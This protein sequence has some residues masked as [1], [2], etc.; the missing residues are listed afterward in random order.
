LALLA[1]CGSQTANEIPPTAAVRGKVLRHD[2]TPFPGGSIEFRSKGR[3]DL[4]LVGEIESDGTF[5]SLRTL[6]ANEQAA[7]AVE[8]TYTVTV[9]PKLSGKPEDQHA[10]PIDVPG[11]FKIAA[12]GENDLTIRLPRPQ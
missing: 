2:Q 1:G 12:S 10:M 8:G 9:M 4:T 6:S 3:T 11:E 5:S 7:G